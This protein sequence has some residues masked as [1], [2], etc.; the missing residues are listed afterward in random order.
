MHAHTGT[1]AHQTHKTIKNVETSRAVVTTVFNPVTGKA[2][3][4][5]ISELEASR[6]KEPRLCRET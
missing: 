3:G 6:S 5:W 4:S 2:E 1:Q